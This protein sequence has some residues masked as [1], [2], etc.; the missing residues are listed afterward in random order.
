MKK[1]GLLIMLAL[2]V[3]IGGVYATWYYTQSD[4][5]ADITNGRALN[6]SDAEFTGTYGGYSVD[7][8]KLVMTVDPKQGTAHVTALYITGEIVV[9]F[10]PSTYAPDDVKSNGVATTCTF[11]V[12]NADWK[13]DETNIVSVDSTPISVVWTRAENGTFTYTI[14]AETLADIITL[15]EITL[16]TKADY[17][18]YDNL[19]TLGQITISVS[20]GKTSAPGA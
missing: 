19:L 5:V 3:S 4:D 10:T 17:D 2:L 6:M 20:D 8:S 1:F 14:S 12:S 9:T 7:T 18:A 11:G 13:Y 15:S 16:D